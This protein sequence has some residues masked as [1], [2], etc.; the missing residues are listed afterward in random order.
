[1]WSALNRQASRT[2]ILRAFSHLLPSS[3]PFGLS[4]GHAAPADAL[5]AFVDR[6][7][8]VFQARVTAKAAAHRAET[9]WWWQR[10]LDTF[11]ANFV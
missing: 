9:R 4:A 1:M 11:A 10:R 6:Q 7:I 8:A 2:A 3:L 5:I